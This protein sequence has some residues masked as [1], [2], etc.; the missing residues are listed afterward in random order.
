M[1]INLIYKKINKINF[2]KYGDIIS[3]NDKNYKEINNGFAYKFDNLA[4]M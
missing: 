2:K 3:I 1:N 4:K